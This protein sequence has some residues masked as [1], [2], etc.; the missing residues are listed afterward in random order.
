MTEQQIPAPEAGDEVV[1]N[2]AAQVTDESTEAEG[3][4][5]DGEEQEGSTSDSEQVSPAKARRER[6]KAEM[7]RL[8][9]ERDEAEKAAAALR[10]QLQDM[11]GG[12]QDPAPKRDDYK[13][14]DEWQAD[15]AAHRVMTRISA[16]ERSGLE[17]QSKEREA[18]LKQLDARERQALAQQWADQETDA[19]TKYADYD[20]VARN[21]SVP[22][23]EVMV[24]AMA[25]SDMGPDIAYWLGRN[26]DAAAR[27]ARM[28][29]HAVGREIGLI[30]A[31]LS[32]PRAPKQ[33]HAPDPVSPVKP[34]A[35]ATKD[36]AR[37]S[38]DEYIAAR[39]SGQ[40]R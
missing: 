21:P 2:Q 7:D 37:M 18:A 33:T 14:Y 5:P 17:T 6:R 36:P 1:A 20:A 28:Q 12:T 19:R 23:S 30:E 40:I 39:K 9:G 34:K 27:I 3:E 8:R 26:P 32:L 16:K 22:I 35:R 10:K 24:Q 11:S 31:R 15:L 38:M 25:S 13:D 4:A 29:P